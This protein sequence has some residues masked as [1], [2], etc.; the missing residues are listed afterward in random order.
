MILAG[1]IGGTKTRLACFTR[2]GPRLTTVREHVF[3]SRQYPSFRLV[4]QDFL[5]LVAQ[6]IEAA[7]LGVAG[8][9]DDGRCKTTNLPWIV[10]EGELAALTGTKT[11]ALL[12][13]LE[14]T[15][16]CIA[17]LEPHEFHVLQAGDLEP[18]GHRAVIAAGTG[19]GEAGIFWN[20]RDWQPFASEGGHADFAPRNELEIDL[21]RYLMGKFGHVSWERVLS[22]PGLVSL[23]EFL[24][25]RYP[26]RVDGQV[27]A[28]IA[29][30]D[31]AAVISQSA[32]DRS[33]G[34]CVEALDWFV[35]LY[36]S[37]AG[38]LALTLMALGG[39]Y[40]AGG[41]APQI[42]PALKQPVFLESMIKGRF[43]SLIE[44][45]PVRVVLND[46]TALWGAAHF[47]ERMM[48]GEEKNA[49]CK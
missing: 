8:P 35:S 34:L 10:E 1:D 3:S 27:A 11:V 7:C 36:G 46:Q 42:L 5:K 18:H 48:A 16:F 30:G 31:A 33:C 20:G 22:G 40:I 9:V 21:L 37:E 12:N 47:A 24:C 15:A 23:Y 14:S 39:V 28:K 44:S 41:I 38:N 43:K 32:L 6:P 45:I 19:L 29:A 2:S 4:L 13:D 17:Y 49:A 26:E 25:H